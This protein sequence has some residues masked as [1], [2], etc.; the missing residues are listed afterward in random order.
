MTWYDASLHQMAQ[1]L[2][3]LDVSLVAY[4]I[5][6]LGGLLTN[7]CPCN[8]ALV[9]MVIGCVGGFSR[10]R[11][12]ARAVLY[13]SVFAAGIVATLCGLGIMASTAG[14]AIAPARTGCLWLMAC[15]A[16]VMGLQCLKVVD[17]PLP[18]LAE[19]PTD[20]RR[21]GL[22]SAFLLGLTAG[23][24]ATP[25]T[26]PVLAVILTYVA[27]KARLFYGVTLL[28]AY[29]CGFV[30]PLIL[31]GAFADFILRLKRL[32]EKTGYRDWIARGSGAWL[33][34]F[35]LYLIKLAVWP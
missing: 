12:R 5:V 18:G 29:A 28:L 32:Q 4:P 2:F 10:S 31:T 24:V 3:S 27:V 34:A 8:V 9:P 22:W 19:L 35:G 15:I 6:F 21:K 26:T 14:A 33:I 13:S 30:V 20:N 23:I 17:L 25:C 1:R 7:F 11:E 16:F